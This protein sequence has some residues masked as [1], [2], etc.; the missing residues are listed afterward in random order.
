[1][2][3]NWF[4][5][6]RKKVKQRRRNEYAS[7]VHRTA[8]LSVKESHANTYSLFILNQRASCLVVTCQISAMGTYIEKVSVQAASLTPYTLCTHTQTHTHTH[9]HT[10]T[11]THTH[12]HTHT[13]THWDSHAVHAQNQSCSSCAKIALRSTHTWC[14]P[15][16]WT[17]AAV[18]IKRREHERVCEAMM[19]KFTMTS[20]ELTVK[21][22]RSPQIPTSISLEGVLEEM[23][24]STITYLENLGIVLQE[25]RGKFEADR[26]NLFLFIL[27]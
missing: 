10:H 18:R 19:K 23:L 26:L 27:I 22:P 14:A 12:T 25:G 5:V 9:T 1:M 24:S 4:W 15:H 2:K 3:C 16:T 11:N 6:G 13:D 8:L 17:H 7:Q 20:L 21:V